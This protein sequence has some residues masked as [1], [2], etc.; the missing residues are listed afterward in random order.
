METW[1]AL[2]DHII[3]GIDANEDV[4]KGDVYNTMMELGLQ[5]VILELHEGES[6]PETCYKNENRV[7]IDGIFATHGITPTTGGYT[8]YDQFCISDHR[9]VWMDVEK[10]VALG[11]NPPNLHRMEPKKFI[12]GKP[13]QRE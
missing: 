8:S 13:E 2:G 10:I 12:A 3:I 6:P 11:Y 9:G 5:E 4:R 7:P 1:L